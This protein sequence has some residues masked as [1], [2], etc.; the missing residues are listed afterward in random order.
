M[1]NVNIGSTLMKKTVMKKKQTNLALQ[2][3]GLKF[4]L[5]VLSFITSWY[6]I[7]LRDKEN[8]STHEVTCIVNICAASQCLVCVCV[9]MIKVPVIY[10]KHRQLRTPVHP[11]NPTQTKSVSKSELQS[12][13]R[14]PKS[15][16]WEQEGENDMGHDWVVE[17]N[18]W[19][20]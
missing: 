20:V 17:V 4:T 5:P 3:P 19:V 18:L 16:K 14:M 9:Y 13:K 10:F 15:R 11:S 6:Q 8:S 1:Y 2:S 12:R 7:A